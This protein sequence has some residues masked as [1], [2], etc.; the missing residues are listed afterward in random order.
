MVFKTS[1]QT[2]QIGTN[3]DEALIRPND[4]GQSIRSRRQQMSTELNFITPPQESV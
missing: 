2:L 1:Y 3:N 4:E